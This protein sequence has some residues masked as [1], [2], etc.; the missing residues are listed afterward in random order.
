MI[1]AVSSWTDDGTGTDELWFA[2]G[3]HGN[4]P[5]PNLSVACVKGPLTGVFPAPRTVGT[6]DAVSSD[7]EYPDV[8]LAWSDTR[9]GVGEIFVKRTDGSVSAST[10]TA[11]DPNICPAPP[12]VRVEWIEPL[13]CDLVAHVV[14]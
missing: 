1:C 10:L 7:E 12:S 13:E 2:V 9:N 5:T 11:A 6:A 14:E 3:T 8:F 4:F